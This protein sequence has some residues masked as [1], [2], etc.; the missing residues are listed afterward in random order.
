MNSEIDALWNSITSLESQIADVNETI[1]NAEIRASV[2]GTVTLIHELSIGDIV[3]A[4]GSL[5]SIIP[6]GDGLK[7]TLYIPESEIAKIAVGQ[8]TEYII[9]AIPYDE[10]GKITGEILS[11]SADSIASESFGTKYYVAQASMSDYSL[12][13]KD[14]LIREVK[15]GM[16]FEAKSISGSKS[17]MTWLLEKL[18]FIE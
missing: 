10:Y 4:G 11:V 12:T 15:I 6:N 3:Q 1:K 9:D 13:N 7:V 14:G 17:V 16:L 2:A 5:C 18:N 8:K